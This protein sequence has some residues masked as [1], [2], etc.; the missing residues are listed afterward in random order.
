[1][2]DI[3]RQLQKYLDKAP[4]GYPSTKSGVELRILKHLFTEEEA[5][6][7]LNLSVIPETVDKI[8][9]RFKKGEMDQEN[10]KRKLDKMAEKGIILS[11]PKRGDKSIRLYNR[12][13][14]AVGMFEFQ[15]DRI[16]KDMAKDGIVLNRSIK[17]TVE[18]MLAM[19]TPSV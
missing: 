15:V 16:T 5:K 9:K 14:L 3:Y 8:V 7:A 12:I 13:P 18:N 17:P 11:I 10:L 19:N 2:E 1:M 4:V 6:I